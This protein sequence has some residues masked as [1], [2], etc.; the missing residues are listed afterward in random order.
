MNN[1]L[2]KNII[3]RPIK[4]MPVILPNNLKKIIESLGTTESELAK[5]LGVQPNYISS[6]SNQKF[7][8]SGKLTIKILNELNITYSVMYDINK[9]IETECNAITDC[10][11]LLECNDILPNDILY[12]LIGE[13]CEKLTLELNSLSEI[14]FLTIPIEMNYDNNQFIPEFTVDHMQ[15]LTPYLVS[16][17]K[18]ELKKLSKEK[19]YDCDKMYYLIGIV[20]YHTQLEKVKISSKNIDID[21]TNILYDL[22]FK[23]LSLQSIPKDNCEFKEDYIVTPKKYQ[24]CTSSGFIETNKIPNEIC[25]FTKANVTFYAYSSEY[26]ANKF[27]AFR[28]LKSYSLDDMANLLECTPETY[29]QIEMGVNKLSNRQMWMMENHLG[30]QLENIIDITNYNK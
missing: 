10:I 28:Q 19:K 4:K 17:Y 29:R 11:L 5:N 7:M 18:K 22:P 9:T 3:H 2:Y 27:K 26:I 8:C 14:K 6:I 20:A 12:K 13:E 23:K 16:L 15:N 21:T 30:V 25:K 1:I 24:L